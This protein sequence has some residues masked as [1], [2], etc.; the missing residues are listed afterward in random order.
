MKEVPG[1]EPPND[2][3]RAGKQARKEEK[4]ARKLAREQQST[5]FG[6]ESQLEANTLAKLLADLAEDV[7]TGQV[8]LKDDTHEL[9]LS[10]AGTARVRLAAR[11]GR[12]KSRLS[13]RVGWRHAE[14]DKAGGSSDK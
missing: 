3:K 6:Q 7:R 5:K 11:R 14:C 1:T 9:M 8:T 2:A 12:K 4:Q 13:I 10:S